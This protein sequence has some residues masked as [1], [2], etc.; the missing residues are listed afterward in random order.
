MTECWRCG[1]VFAKVRGVGS[2]APG[3]YPSVAHDD[4]GSLWDRLL[5]TLVATQE[6]PN[7]VILAGRAFW[8]L[9][10][11]AMSWGYVTWEW[12]NQEAPSFAHAILSRANLIFHES[13]HIIFIPFGDFMR[14]LG[15]SIMQCLVPLVC[16]VAFLGFKRHAF[17]ASAM[18]W[19]TGVNLTEVARYMYDAGTQ[20]LVLLGGVTG[21]EAPG[22]HD[23]NNLL[24]RLDLMKYDHALGRA[25]SHAGSA[26]IVLGL[27]WGALL[28]TR[29]YR[30]LKSPPGGLAS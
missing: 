3:V 22:Y 23:W 27:V 28:L 30:Q 5:A 1:V 8:L 12:T 2:A 7:P 19:W 25:T 24:G 9:L 10:A 26:L 29:E 17:G 4:D 20:G 14:V 16:M 21:D 15:G 13:G 18:L 11:A 6:Q